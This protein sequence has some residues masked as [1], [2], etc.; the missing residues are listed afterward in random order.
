[1]TTEDLLA[2]HNV[3]GRYAHIMDAGSRGLCSFEEFVHVFT[4]D[5]VF[6]FTEAGGP[7][8]NGRDGIVAIMAGSKHPSGHHSTNFVIEEIDADHVTVLSKILSVEA[9]GQANTGHYF[10]HIDRTPD[11]WR[12][13][14]RTAT[15]Y[16]AMPRPS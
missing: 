5:A 9:N 10:D 15:V 14:H 4:E 11:G 12:I 13:R 8:V 16:F 2:I 6:D 1:V 7:C 3:L